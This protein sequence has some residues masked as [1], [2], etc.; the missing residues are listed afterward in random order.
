MTAQLYQSR[1]ESILQK[2]DGGVLCRWDLPA[3]SQGQQQQQQQYSSAAPSALK[4][5]LPPPQ[6]P[7]ANGATHM[8]GLF[9]TGAAP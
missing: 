8:Q 4:Q 3:S 7:A 5:Q 6:Q 1:Q 9:S 2:A